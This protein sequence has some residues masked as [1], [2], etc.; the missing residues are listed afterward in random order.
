MG[1]FVGDDLMD[2]YYWHKLLIYYKIMGCNY[3]QDRILN[4]GMLGFHEWTQT[5]INPY[6][7][8]KTINY[9]M[10]PPKIVEDRS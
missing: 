4:V 1:Y 9:S 7:A 3:D 5:S 10:R 2:H 8:W 6:D